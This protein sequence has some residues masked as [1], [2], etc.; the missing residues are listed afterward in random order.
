MF[1]PPA[2]FDFKD[3]SDWP[4]WQKSF[5]RF[6]SCTELHKKDSTI[7]VDSLIYAMGPE[8]ENIIVQLGLSSE[9]AK[10][11][12]VVLAK[13]DSY[14]KP[15]TNVIYERARLNQRCQKPGESMQQFITSLY[16]LAENCQY[17][18]AAKD[19]QIRDRLVSGIRDKNLSKELQ[20]KADLTL[21][22]AIE[23]V[24][25]SELVCS[26]MEN[27]EH[28]M[29][30]VRFKPPQTKQMT[31]N[32][33]NQGRKPQPHPHPHHQ[34]GSHCMRCGKSHDRNRMCS[35][36][37]ATCHYCGK[38]GHFAVVC[39]IKKQGKPRVAEIQLSN[40]P[41]NQYVSQPTVPHVEEVSNLQEDVHF[42]GSIDN[43][44][45]DDKPWLTNVDINGQSCA[46]KIDTGADVC[47]MSEFM[48]KS[49]KCPPKLLETEIVLKSYG[50][51][52]E[53]LGMFEAGD[54]FRFPVYVV[55][56]AGSNLLS[57]NVS[58]K[59]GLITVNIDEFGL[60]KCDPVKIALQDDA[61]PYHVNVARR[62]PIPLVSKV[63]NELDKM[64]QEGIIRS[65][66][67]PTE[68]CAP[69]VVVMKKSGNIRICVD[70]KGLNKSIK[71]E[72]YMLPTVE[73][74]LP[75]L[76]GAT[77]FSKLD[78]ASGYW[79]LPLDEAS[80]LL[81]TF[82]TPKGRY[83]FRRLPFG[84][85]SASEIFQREMTRILD[86]V[87]GVCAYQD[88]I[89]IYGTSV[90]EHDKRLAECM[91]KLTD[92]GL[93]LN[94]A[95]CEIGKPTIEFL[96]HQ[97]SKHGISPDKNKVK[98]VTEIKPPQNV[99]E[100]R[101]TLG[102]IQ[103]LGR[104]IPNLSDLLKPMND[105]LSK[106]A[107]WH[108]GEKQQESL[109]K[110]KHLVT[111]AP[112]LAYFDLSKETVVSADASSYGIGGFLYQKHGNELKPVAFCS[113]TLTPAETHYAQIEKECLACTWVCE[114]FGH[115]LTG[116]E[117]FKLITDHKPLLPLINTKDIVNTPVRCQRL[118][119]RLMKFNVVAEHCPGTEMYVADALSRNPLPFENRAQ[120]DAIVEE[121]EAHVMMVETYWPAT[122]RRLEQIRQVTM[123]DAT[124]QK[125]LHFTLHGWPN[126]SRA[127]DPSLR[128]YYTER[129]YLSHSDGLLLYCDR[130]VIPASMRT[131]ILNCIHEGHWG[132]T[133]CKERAAR[134]VWWPNITVDITEKVSACPQCITNQS[135]QTKQPLITR[136]LPDYPWQRVAVDLFEQNGRHFMV[137]VDM[138][139]RFL[140]IAYLPTTSS[141]AVIAK[142]K[143]SFARFGV[144]QEVLSD[145][146]PQFS[147]AEFRTFAES[148]GFKHTTSS[149][150]YPQSN[151]AAESAVKNAKRITSQPDP[152]KALLSYHSTPIQATGLSPAEAMY[153]R[154]P[155]TSVPCIPEKLLPKEIDRERVRERDDSYKEKMA[156]FYDRKNGVKETQPLIPGEAVR[157]RTDNE[158]SWSTTGTITEQV[159]PRSYN[160]STSQGTYRRTTQHLMS[161][162]SAEQTNSMLL[163]GTERNVPTNS[164][165]VN[166]GAT[167]NA[168]ANAHS[169]D[170]GYITRSGRTVKPVNKLTLEM[171]CLDS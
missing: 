72:R 29:D 159:A 110:V 54:A 26:Q 24:R 62:V 28:S 156:F 113:R 70:L 147:S 42:L 10:N 17:E 34:Q 41:T 20:M 162:K 150:H 128:C 117:K 90:E 125:V 171:N 103:Y 13:L 163:S 149:P 5:M 168:I 11:I 98:A 124:L 126:Q 170:S 111:S 66:T 123:S 101:S 73:D 12:D 148:W 164:V 75:K 71:R 133:K 105:L 27:L 119:L 76:T 132:I 140:E 53:V 25:H 22:K 16:E 49:L 56:G 157:V 96:G 152:F 135:R 65:V 52:P 153:G 116:L 37:R 2:P 57:R 63:E 120:I 78:A 61:V 84:I 58:C 39:R 55:K 102:M 15:Q 80:S 32:Y 130:I 46:F 100:L 139:S 112:L 94:K 142:I 9:D 64:E 138:Y 51:K 95:K 91:Q 30:E 136:P 1:K 81:T 160:V 158:K 107:Q 60:V 144:A 7:Q 3:P 21:A 31:S 118:L 87:K 93:R 6:R 48:Y 86:G 35:A 143:N 155:K 68:W 82:I 134:S 74:I 161:D 69:M 79:Q 122:A 14:F 77:V 83:C 169:Q 8:A 36:A 19:E 88:D 141:T 23:M 33:G 131:D 47:V 137:Q 18:G 99:T 43:Q 40:Q 115:Y 67:E 121:I 92:V 109:D 127:I 129:A 151:G 50:G 104:Y 106:H 167:E 166:N 4:R 89:L 38:M 165:T 108:W 59:L 85:S 45:I 114:R 44:D 146:G 145:N 97:I 154:L